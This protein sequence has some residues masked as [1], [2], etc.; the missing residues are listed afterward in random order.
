MVVILFSNFYYQ[1]IVKKKFPQNT[2]LY[3][4]A[5]KPSF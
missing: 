5:Q 2:K 1:T 3:S 4:S